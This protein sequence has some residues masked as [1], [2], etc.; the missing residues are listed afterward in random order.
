MNIA[1]LFAKVTE[2]IAAWRAG[3]WKTVA[4]RE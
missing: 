4:T 1:T 3:D 2:A